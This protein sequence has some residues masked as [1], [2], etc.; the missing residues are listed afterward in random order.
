MTTTTTDTRAIGV[1]FTAPRQI[2]MEETEV[3]EPGPGQVLLKAEKTLISTG[4]ELT[5]LTGEFPTGSNWAQYVRYPWNPGYSF[6]GRVLATGTG[7]EHLQPGMRAIAIAPHRSYALADA[8]RTVPLLDGV[9]DEEG[10]FVHLAATVLN[11]VRLPRIELGESVAI[12]GAGL[13][14]QMCAQF[15]R[16]SGGLPVIMIDP[17]EGRLQLAK[18]LGAHHTLSLPVGEAREAVIRLSKNRGI[19]SKQIATEGGA[20]VVFEITG[21]PAVVP[22][23]INLVRREGRVVLLGS[24]RGPSQI[25]LG[26]TVHWRGLVL[27]GAHGGTTPTV[28]TVQTPWTRIRN[29]EVIMELILNGGFNVRDLISHRFPV[30]EAAEAYQ[31]LLEDRTKAM[32]V[33]L[34]WSSQ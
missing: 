33:I 16:L 17:A 20:D 7:V 1:T 21:S 10:A 18:R 25:D 13:L 32:G 27:L 28:E 2:V 14:G 3:R 30:T 5:G 19:P 22:G 26:D 8:A 6:V 4:T 34:D 24:S 15:V 31:M 29:E 9:S 23:A 11:G 12:V